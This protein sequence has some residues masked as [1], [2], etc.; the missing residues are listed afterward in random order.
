MRYRKMWHVLQSTKMNVELW[1]G[2]L[3]QNEKAC[4]LCSE[5]PFSIIGLDTN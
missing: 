3:K 5:G 2:K 4:N 1:L